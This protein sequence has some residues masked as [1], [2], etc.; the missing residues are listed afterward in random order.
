MIS[1]KA[2]QITAAN[3]LTESITIQSNTTCITEY[4]PTPTQ[5]DKQGICLKCYQLT[6]SIIKQ[7]GCVEKRFCYK[8]VLQ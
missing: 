6:P 1:E 4:R 7:K 8:I 5:T 3:N 2:S